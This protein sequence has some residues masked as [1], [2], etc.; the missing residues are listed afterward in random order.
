MSDSGLIFGFSPKHTSMVWL[1]LG[2]PDAP[3]KIV[4]IVKIHRVES[5]EKREV[6]EGKN[7]ESSILTTIKPTKIY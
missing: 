2:L 5:G 3:K 4:F 6:E 7:P 1:S